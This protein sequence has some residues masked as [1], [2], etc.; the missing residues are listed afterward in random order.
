MIFKNIKKLFKA[1]TTYITYFP[2]AYLNYFFIE[3]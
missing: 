1:T 2:E 3:L